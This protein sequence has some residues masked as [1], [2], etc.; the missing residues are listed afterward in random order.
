MTAH[1]FAGWILILC[2]CL[3]QFVAGMMQAS[4]SISSKLNGI[5]TYRQ[6]LETHTAIICYRLVLVLSALIV[7]SYNPSIVFDLLKK[8]TPN[9]AFDVPLNPGTAILLGIA[10]DSIL[11]KIGPYVGLRVEVPPK[12]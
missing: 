10:G 12:P 11:D 2:C 6:Y 4:N 1:H 3:G 8:F 5:E 9:Y 7:W